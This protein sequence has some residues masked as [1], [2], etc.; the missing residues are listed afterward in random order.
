MIS[1]VHRIQKGA[2]TLGRFKVKRSIYIRPA[3]ANCTLKRRER[4][5]P[6]VVPR[7]WLLGLLCVVWPL[8]FT[9]PLCAAESGATNEYAAV[10]A[11]FTEHCLDCH[12]AQ[13]PKGHLVL[14]DF[15]S[16]MK[17]G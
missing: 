10:N 4:R 15:D 9:R 8:I 6:S 12:G 5:A 1:G 3:L 17:G 2:R 14:E 11:I 16:L 13:E 7:F